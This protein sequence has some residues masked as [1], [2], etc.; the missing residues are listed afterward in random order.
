MDCGKNLKIG[1]IGPRSFVLGG[2]D[3]QNS[4]RSDLREKFKSILMRYYSDNINILGVTGLGLGSEQDFALS[5]ADI[6]IDYIGVLAFP[7]QEERWPDLPDVQKQY[8]EL[9]DRANH[10]IVM[11][12]GRY[13]PK[14]IIEKNIKIIEMCDVILYVYCSQYPKS[15]KIIDLAEK[16][17]K[18]IILI[19]A[20]E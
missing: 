16:N 9:C 10:T 11:N 17:N 4:I 12:E 14:K 13:S 3:Y 2:H 6:G 7:D 5:C 15:T 19:E 1:V 8:R 20:R 18:A